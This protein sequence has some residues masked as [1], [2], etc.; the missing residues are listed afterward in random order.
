MNPIYNV[1]DVVEPVCIAG[2]W[3]GDIPINGDYHQLR[4]DS[5][6]FRDIGTIIDVKECVIDYDTWPSLYEGLGK[7][8]YTSY[9]IKCDAGIGW[10][11]EGSI[12]LVD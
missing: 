5:C 2:L 7:T 3:L 4:V 9:L 10:A 1:G 6:L 8:K 12:R 11:G